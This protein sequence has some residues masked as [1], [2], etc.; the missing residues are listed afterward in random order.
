MFA[1]YFLASLRQELRINPYATTTRELLDELEALPGL[2]D[3]PDISP[4]SLPFLTMQLEKDDLKLS[5]FSVV[6]T[7][8][9][10]HD[11]TL[12]QLR[13]ETFFP[14]DKDTEQI[15]RAF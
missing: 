7:F 9:H 12:Q 5:L 1:N 13:I 6:S 8:G 11:V 2:P 10:P 3:I 4:P 14:A 15:I